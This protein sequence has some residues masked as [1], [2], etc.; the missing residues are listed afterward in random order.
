MA[1]KKYVFHVT[2]SVAQSRDIVIKASSQE[3][4]EEKFDAQREETDDFDDDGWEN[5]D[6]DG[7][8][9]WEVDGPPD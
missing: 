3:E 6:P 9:D 8:L 4:A 7:P 2:R 1:A 5:G